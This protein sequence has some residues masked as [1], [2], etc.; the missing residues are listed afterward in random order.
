MTMK[1]VSLLSLLFT[2]GLIT[3]ECGDCFPGKSLEELKAMRDEQVKMIPEYQKAE[4]VRKQHAQK[5]V[6]LGRVRARCNEYTENTNEGWLLRVSAND[7]VL[8]Q[9]YDKDFS[10]VVKLLHYAN[11]KANG[12]TSFELKEICD[13]ILKREYD[14]IEIPEEVA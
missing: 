6:K 1:N 3:A 13:C 5:Q 4:T 11:D 7:C 8:A 14:A 12:A 9:Q 2:V 10:D